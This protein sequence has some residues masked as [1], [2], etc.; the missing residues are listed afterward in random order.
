MFNNKNKA[1]INSV[2]QQIHQ[3]DERRGSDH[4]A[5]NVSLCPIQIQSGEVST[6]TLVPVHLWSAGTDVWVIHNI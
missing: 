4:N 6:A 3:N 2:D 1:E 5:L